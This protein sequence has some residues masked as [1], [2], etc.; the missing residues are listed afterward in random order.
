MNHDKTPIARNMMT[1]LDSFKLYAWLQTADLNTLSTYRALA[2]AAEKAIGARVTQDNVTNALAEAAENIGARVT[3]A[4]VT[5]A[6]ADIGRALPGRAPTDKEAIGIIAA[7]LFELMKKLGVDASED[8]AA[9]AASAPERFANNTFYT[10]SANPF[11]AGFSG[12]KSGE[13]PV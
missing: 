10:T 6:L 5:N 9:L 11:F 3:Q 4:N 7:A 2:E 13:T 12:Q 1:K 8:L